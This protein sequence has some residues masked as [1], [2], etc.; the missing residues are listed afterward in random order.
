MPQFAN[1]RSLASLHPI[2]RRD[3]VMR[4][5]VFIACAAGRLPADV[6]AN[7]SLPGLSP[8]ADALV[9]Y[10]LCRIVAC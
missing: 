3:R 2:R 1:V 10:S 9:T 6:C 5:L 7:A 4:A 8:A